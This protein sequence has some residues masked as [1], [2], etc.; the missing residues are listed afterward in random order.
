[1]SVNQNADKQLSW[2]S[3]DGKTLLVRQLRVEELDS[4][5][6]LNREQ[7]K[8]EMAPKE[9]ARHLLEY[10]PDTIWGVYES[11][12]RAA[13]DE[14]L[15]GYLAFLMLNEDGASALKHGRLDVLHPPAALI[16]AS[17]ERPHLIYVWAVVARGLGAVAVPLTTHAM[18][19][20]YAGLSLCGTA[21][22]EA[23]AKAMRGFGFKPLHPDKPDVGNLFWLDRSSMPQAEPPEATKDT[24]VLASRFK[25]VIA[26]S[27]LEVQQAFAIRAGAFMI[28][29]SCPFGEEF[30]GNDYTATHLVG[31]MDGEPAATLRIRY[32]ADF[33]KIE[34]LAVLPRFRGSLLYREVV[35]TALEFCR[36]KGYVKAYGHA[37]RRLVPLWS[38]FGFKVIE[39]A[40]PFVFSDHEYLEM[41]AVLA[42][43]A[44]PIRIGCDPLV[45]DR[46]EGAWDIPGILDLSSA[47][48]PTNP[49]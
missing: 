43:H 24:H 16:A 21:A 35:Q 32:F 48:L 17:G 37:Q 25:V 41:Q 30:D 4:V 23:G 10:N 1:M 6:A 7:L 26:R 28:E 22:T 31:Y 14:R 3:A 42:P 39:T 34:R 13:E 20:L 29:Q 18:G 49:H 36:R 47:R 11:D 27:S 9:E 5:Y 38:R 2:T 8:T 44:S 12:D 40:A 15:V 46:P 45:L 33:V 19:S